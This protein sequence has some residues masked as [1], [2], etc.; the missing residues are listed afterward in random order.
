LYS[1]SGLPNQIGPLAPDKIVF[2]DGWRAANAYLL[3]NLRFTGWHRSE[4][5]N[6]VALV[7]QGERIVTDVLDAAP[8]RWLPV[9][10]S[11]VRDKRI[12]RENLNSLLVENSGL[13]AVM[14]GLTGI[15][16]QWA[17]DPPAYAEVL[18][19]V[20]GQQIGSRL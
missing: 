10:R 8:I 15:G 9:G 16:S 13:S 17:Q 18:N 14:D 2:R 12:P 6:A 4:A 5:T 3:L 20:T 1:D 11:L 19:F 7:Y